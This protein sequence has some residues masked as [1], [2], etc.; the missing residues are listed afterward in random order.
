MIYVYEKA[1]RL[2]RE[3]ICCHSMQYLRFK[4]NAA[5]QTIKCCLEL[6]GENCYFFVNSHEHYIGLNGTLIIEAEPTRSNG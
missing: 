3:W 5:V 6:M 2:K 1:E 4:T